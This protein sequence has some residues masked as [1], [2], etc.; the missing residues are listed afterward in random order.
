MVAPQRNSPSGPLAAS[1]NTVITG[2]VS[3]AAQSVAVQSVALSGVR[4]T[5]VVRAVNAALPTG[6]ALGGNSR[7]TATDQIE[8]SIINPTVGAVST[9]TVTYTVE[10]G[11][12][13]S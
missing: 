10:I 12:Y 11:G 13:T 5:D 3:V 4:V 7:V 8:L 9:G 2:D 1:K 6:L